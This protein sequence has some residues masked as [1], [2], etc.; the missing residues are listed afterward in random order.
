MHQLSPALSSLPGYGTA[1]LPWVSR[2]PG[3]HDSPYMIKMEPARDSCDGMPGTQG[4]SQ[5]VVQAGFQWNRGLLALV[6]YMDPRLAR[7]GWSVVPPPDPSSPPIGEWIKTLGNATR[8]TVTISH[9]GL[10]VWQLVAT[11]DP[12]GKAASGC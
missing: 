3:S 12:I 5:V 1:T 2:L 10:P 6:A 4:W 7:L 9:E 11:A 8:A